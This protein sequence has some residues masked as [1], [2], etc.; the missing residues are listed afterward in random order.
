[1]DVEI[2]E[3]INSNLA[4]WPNA[5]KDPEASKYFRTDAYQRV[6]PRYKEIVWQY[7]VRSNSLC[8]LV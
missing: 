4:P 2:A 3:S 6:L 5:W 8:W 1:M 7:A